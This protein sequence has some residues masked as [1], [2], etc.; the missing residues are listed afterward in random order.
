MAK[1]QQCLREWRRSREDDNSSSNNGL[2][3]ADEEVKDEQNPSEEDERTEEKD[4]KELQVDAQESGQAVDDNEECNV[5]FPF[6]PANSDSVFAMCTNND[7]ASDEEDANKYD[8]NNNIDAV[9]TYPSAVFQALE[10]MMLHSVLTDLTLFTD[11]GYRFQ[12]HSFVLAAVSYLIQTR[13]RQK[14]KQEQF[15]SLC[16]GPKV[17]G[18]GL[19]AVV[20]FAYTG[21]IDI[22]NKKNIEQIWSAAVSLEAPRILELCKEEEEREEDEAGGKKVDRKEISAEEHI[23]ISLQHIRQ[24]WTQRMG[25]D[26]ELEAEGRVFH[27]HRAL[28]AASSDYFRGMFTNGMKESRQ[29]LVS[30]LLVGA[31][32]FEVLLHYTYSGALVLGWGCV[33]D[34]TCTSLQLQFQT[35]FSLCLNFLQQEIDAYNCLD[36]ASFAESFGMGDLLALAN[37]Y[38][39][40]H[41]QDVSVTPKFQDLPAEKLK[42]YLQSDSLCVPSELPVFR[43]VM[44]WIEAFPRQRVKLARELM[45][46]VQFPLMTFKE[47][48]EVK[49]ITSWPRIGA[50]KLYDSLLEEFCSSSSDVQSNFRAYMPKD[51]LVLVGGERITDNFDK[52]RPCREM[53]FSNSLQNH[54]GLVK[55]VE[56]RMLGTLPVKPRFSHGVGVMRGK[57]YVVGGRHY[58]GKADTM[59]CTYRYDP[60]QNSWQRLTDMHE[61]RGSFTLVVLNGKIYAIGGERDSGV[62]MESAE[63]YCPN[64]NSWSF[65]H[66]LDQALCCHAATVWNG[67]IFLSG[68]FNNQYQCLS[69]MTLY[70]PERGSTYLAEMT[71]DRALHCM[72][73]LGDRLYVAGGVSCNADGHLLDQLACEVYNPVANSWSAIMPFPV[74]HVGSASAVLEGKVYVIGGYCQEDYNDT[75]TVHRYD[76]ATE[77]WENMSITPGPNTYIAAC[78]LPIPAHLRQ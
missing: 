15:I 16:L 8:K 67:T 61:R 38:V 46:T 63:V 19:A 14:P 33:F 64:T 45:G 3:D 68:G 23:K 5:S 77:R 76:P 51:A 48:K 1:D 31:A 55:K 10:N 4:T 66:P 52:R 9:R 42:K 11:D 22:R 18:S 13:L 59:N 17:H 58:Y 26:V 40:R 62:N 36:V 39:L 32:K 47:F 7:K 29:E 56:W 20:E 12:V 37:D 30:L 24:M 70:H 54:V 27:A 75:K 53:W 57:L 65:V 74:P 28:L 34:L 71:H 43:A 69:S 41:F 44:S 49:S 21:Y 60:I 2:I 78:V 73:T 35:A 25:C 6:T 50:K 72:E